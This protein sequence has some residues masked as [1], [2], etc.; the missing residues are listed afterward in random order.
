MTGVDGE[1]PKIVACPND[2][3]Q[4]C[5]DYGY[6]VSSILGQTISQ[7][8]FAVSADQYVKYTEPS[9]TIPNALGDGDSTTG[10]LKYAMH[11]Y[12]VRFNANST[13]FEGHIY[14]LG[15]STPRLGTAYV[16]GGKV[17]EA[18]AIAGPGTSGNPWAPFT[19]SENVV[20]AGGKCAA[21]LKYGGNGK[22]IGI[23]LPP[24]SPCFT[25]KIPD[26]RVLTLD[27]VTPV[28]DANGPITFGN[29]TTTIYMPSGYA[30]CTASPCPGTLYYVY[31]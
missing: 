2:P 20:A 29:G 23:T 27:G 13:V 1:F 3:A 10:F 4:Q 14:I 25:G 31:K 17:D 9:P 26:D 11:E 19:T 12:P 16:R 21:T 28:R 30:I 5:S 22:V 7:T 8:L 15:T 18:C 6:R 24:N